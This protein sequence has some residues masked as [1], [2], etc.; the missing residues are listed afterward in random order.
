MAE[1]GEGKV[2]H[3]Y[4]PLLLKLNE[5]G[6]KYIRFIMW[7]QFWVESSRSMDNDNDIDFGFTLRRSRLLM[8]AQVSPRFLILTH[9]GANSITTR[10]LDPVGASFGPSFF[11]HDAWMEFSI[12]DNYI[13]AGAGLHYWNGISRLTNQSTLS[14]VTIDAPRFNWPTIGTTDQFARHLGIYLKGKVGGFDYRVSVNQPL[15]NTLDKQRDLEPEEGQAV[16]VHEDKFVYAGY[17]MYQFLERESNKLPFMTGTYLGEKKVL[18]LGAGFNI[19]PKGSC[20]LS[21]NDTMFHTVRLFGAD[22]FTDIPFGKRRNQAFTGYFVFYSYN[23]GPNYKLGGTSDRV[24]TGNI[25]YG[26][27][28]YLFPEFTDKGR[29]Q[30]YGAHSLRELDAYDDMGNT[31][32]VGAT[33]FILGH[34]AKL[35]FEYINDQYAGGGNR[36]GSIRM[37]AAI[38]L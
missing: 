1:E 19:H 17:F 27:L 33:W 30:L 3:S 4:Y 38:M 12:K 9:F 6:S 15:W 36:V 23:F 2:D 25:Y 8:L 21:G 10:N 16:Y 18:N 29:L 35:S 32:T 37:Q 34:S 14:M 22:F 7:H 13:S 11:I 5:D 26:Q 20:Y 31:F 28:G 24:A